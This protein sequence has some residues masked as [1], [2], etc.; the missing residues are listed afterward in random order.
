MSR[1][2]PL[3]DGCGKID[4]W[5]WACWQPERPPDP[6]V[7]WHY[8]Y[9]P[10]DGVQYRSNSLGE[11]VPAPDGAGFTYC[12]GCAI[13]AEA[14]CREHPDDSKVAWLYGMVAAGSNPDTPID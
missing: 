14:L 1:D 12:P 5:W 3:L 2:W 8:A 4:L 13:K 6:Y 9:N 11:T 10:N 7:R